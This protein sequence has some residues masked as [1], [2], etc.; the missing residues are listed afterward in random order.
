MPSYGPPA[1]C[2]VSTLSIALLTD[3]SVAY[4]SSILYRPGS[5]GLNRFDEKPNL[6]NSD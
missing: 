5:N 6:V 3:G 2:T 1:A 4:V